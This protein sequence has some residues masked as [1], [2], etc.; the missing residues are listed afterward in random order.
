MLEQLKELV[1]KAKELLITQRDTS[2]VVVERLQDTQQKL[3]Q[4]Q[5]L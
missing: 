5:R 3:I 1:W 2:S 4:L